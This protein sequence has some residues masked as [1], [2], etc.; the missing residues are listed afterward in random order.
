MLDGRR[1][2]TS[3][4]IESSQLAMVRFSQE[5]FLLGI[6]YIFPYLSITFLH[7]CNSPTPSQR[8]K[9]MYNAYIV[10]PMA[11]VVTILVVVHVE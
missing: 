5:P 2:T 11:E 8:G 10:L 4:C 7:F 1:A 6:L 3:L 9:L